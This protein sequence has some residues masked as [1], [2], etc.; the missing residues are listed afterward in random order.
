[1][2]LHRVVLLLGILLLLLL[3]LFLILLLSQSLL[4]QLSWCVTT[5]QL[6]QPIYCNVIFHQSS[7]I[8]KLPSERLLAKATVHHSDTRTNEFMDMRTNARAYGQ[9]SSLAH[10]TAVLSSRNPI[11]RT[12]LDQD[13]LLVPEQPQI[14]VHK[15]DP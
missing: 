15:I 11:C 14:H 7:S 12:N 5:P 13:R 10:D 2:A 9:T 3:F 6:P 4:E 8:I 1:M